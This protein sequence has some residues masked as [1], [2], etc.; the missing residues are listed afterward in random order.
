MIDFDEDDPGMETVND[1]SITKLNAFRE[2]YYPEIGVSVMVD[3]GLAD[4]GLA[5]LASPLGVVFLAS[6]I[7]RIDEWQRL[8]K[9]IS[10]TSKALAYLTLLHE[11]GHFKLG[12]LRICT[13]DERAKIRPAQTVYEAVESLPRELRVTALSLVECEQGSSDAWAVSEYRRLI[14]EGVL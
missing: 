13:Q 1:I 2:K 10:L 14:A 9:T 12:H 4:R 11:I 5:G 7:T 3:Y 8:D 6:E